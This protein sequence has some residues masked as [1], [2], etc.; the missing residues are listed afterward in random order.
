MVIFIKFLKPDHWYDQMNMWTLAAYDL[1]T[2]NKVEKLHKIISDDQAGSI[3][4]IIFPKDTS[5]I[6]AQTEPDL[7]TNYYP[8]GNKNM[9]SIVS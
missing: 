7:K 1:L 4:N 6:F 8:I 5:P 2:R 9:L 3:E